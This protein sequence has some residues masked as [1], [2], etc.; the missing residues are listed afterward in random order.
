MANGSK[1]TAIVNPHVADEAIEAAIAP[2][3]TVTEETVKAAETAAQPLNEVQGNL[4]TVVEKGLVETRNAY[5]KAKSNADEAA[6]AFETS[7]AAAKAGVVA[8]N[9]KALD[10]LRAN[11]EANLDFVKSAIAARNVADYVTLQGEFARKQLEAMTDQTK[12]LSEL[13]RKLAVETAEPIKQ[14][15]AKSFRISA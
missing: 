13:T 10:A 11:V 4:R 12:A 8:I 2:V 15:V 7:Y 14:Q 1:R 6:S 5:A 3:A 9:A